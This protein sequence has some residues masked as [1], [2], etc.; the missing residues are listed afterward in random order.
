ML[1]RRRRGLAHRDDVGPGIGVPVLPAQPDPLHPNGHGAGLLDALNSQ[2]EIEIRSF[3]K[4]EDTLSVP[5]HTLIFVVVKF[6]ESFLVLFSLSSPSYP[7]LSLLIFP[8]LFVPRSTYQSPRSAQEGGNQ[9][10]RNVF[11][12]AAAAETNFSPLAVRSGRGERGRQK[13]EMSPRDQ[14][15]EI[16]DEARPQ[17]L[18]WIR[19]GRKVHLEK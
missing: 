13:D 4:L 17:F 10:K 1:S 11:P 12:E 19:G 6:P 2:P 15:S 5:P 7:Q 8:P 18:S 3:E 9:I 14:E 16:P